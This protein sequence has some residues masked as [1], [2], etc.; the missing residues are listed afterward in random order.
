LPTTELEKSLLLAKLPGLEAAKASIE[1]EIG[2]IRS[3]FWSDAGPRR[4]GRVAAAKSVGRPRGKR[5]GPSKEGRKR[6][7]EMMKA[8]WAARKA[9][10][11]GKAARKR[12]S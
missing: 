12:A 7:S 6:I 4:R 2:K 8:R 1:E 5:R 10:E 3:L 9:A 11:A